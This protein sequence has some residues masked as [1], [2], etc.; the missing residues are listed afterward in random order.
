VEEQ[1]ERLVE[2]EQEVEEKEQEVEE[3]ELLRP[4]HHNVYTEGTDGTEHPV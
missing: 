1:V 4:E 3:Q 2:K